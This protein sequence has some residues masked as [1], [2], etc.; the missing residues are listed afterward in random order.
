MKYYSEHTGPA[1]EKLLKLRSANP[2]YAVIEVT[3]TTEND[4][5]VLAEFVEVISDSPGSS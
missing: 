5:R 1:G 4:V 2:D 3:P